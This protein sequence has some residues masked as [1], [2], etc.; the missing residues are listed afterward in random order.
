MERVLRRNRVKEFLG[1]KVGK[2]IMGTIL[3]SVIGIVLPKIF[4]L[5]GGSSAGAKFLPMHIAVLIATMAFGIASG[6]IVAGTSVLSSYLLTGMPS[7]QKLPYMLLELLI[8]VLVLSI[9]NKK[10]NFY[11]SLIG[12]III[13]RIIYAG[14]LF[15][16]ANIIGLNLTGIT[17]VW[18]ATSTGIYGI[19]LQIAFIPF[20]AKEVKKG[21]KIDG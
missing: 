15:I 3:L 17:S 6:S 2:Q 10:F 14:V 19:L 13:G 21:L 11:V 1:S 12:T 5:L 7:I 20:I 16:S 9:L 18:Q 4:H 8:Y